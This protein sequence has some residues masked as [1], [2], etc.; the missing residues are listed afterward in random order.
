MC[1]SCE[2]FVLLLLNCKLNIAIKIVIERGKIVIE[3]E[4]RRAVSLINCFNTRTTGVE[5]RPRPLFLV[6][7]PG[8]YCF[9]KSWFQKLNEITKMSL[10]I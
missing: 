8:H 7:K 1:N 6:L 9:V 5:F 3:R 4:L 2:L 10:W